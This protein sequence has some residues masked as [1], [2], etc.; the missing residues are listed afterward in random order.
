VS[1]SFSASPTASPTPPATLTA[2]LSPSLTPGG[3][4][5]IS[6][7]APLPQPNPRQVA[8]LLAGPADG[9]SLKAYSVN[10]VL[11][12]PALWM[13]GVG[14]GWNQVNIQTL[15]T[16]LPNGVYFLMVQAQR[17]S[18][19]SPVCRARLVILK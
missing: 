7:V 12:R 2:T 1:P 16:G 15:V 19:H 8:V 13:K 10:W 3:P 6:K 18:S 9:I 14:P 17:G 11:V 5:L 4:L